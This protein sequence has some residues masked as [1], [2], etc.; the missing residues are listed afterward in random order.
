MSIRAIAASV[1]ILFLMF[2]GWWCRGIYED[3]KDASELRARLEA[4]QKF[5]ARESKVAGL[6]EKRLA[7]LKANETVIE[8]EKLKLVERPVYRSDC[9]DADGLRLIGRI[10]SGSNAEKPAGEVS[11]GAPAAAGKDGR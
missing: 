10:A 4:E 8:R 11:D 3:A 1:G 6:V 5:D 2:V 9:I 7:E